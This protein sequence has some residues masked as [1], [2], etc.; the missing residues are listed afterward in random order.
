VRTNASGDGPLATV[1]VRWKQPYKN[2][3]ANSES[4]AA[5]EIAQ[6]VFSKSATG[7]FN[8]TSAGYRRAVLVAQFAEFLRRSIHARNDSVDRLA[9]EARKLSGELKDPEFAEFVAMVD[10]SRALVIAELARRDCST[11][12]AT[13]CAGAATCRRRSTT[14]NAA[15]V[16]SAT[17]TTCSAT[18]TTCNASSTNLRTHL[19]SLQGQGDEDTCTAAGRKHRAPTAR[20][21]AAR[22]GPRQRRK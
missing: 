19:E 3:V 2:G 17:S 18:P 9:D 13:N 22:Q 11:A 4:D 12:A 6:Q 8:A 14:C 16:A 15:S 7:S 5:T 10:K 1:H 21:R 20:D